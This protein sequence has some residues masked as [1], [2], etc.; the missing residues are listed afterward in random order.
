MGLSW[1]RNGS[2]GP[3]I[4]NGPP[5]GLSGR[6]SPLKLPIGLVPLAS[7]WSG[8]PGKVINDS[9][10]LGFGGRISALGGKGPGGPLGFIILGNPLP[11]GPSGGPWKLLGAS[12]SAGC[13]GGRNRGC[14]VGAL[15]MNPCGFIG[16]FWGLNPGGFDNSPPFF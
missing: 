1:R 8:G 2:R 3:L 13:L 16:L 10:I 14:P 15:G 11:C 9:G 12:I 5:C 4:C 6:N 7:N